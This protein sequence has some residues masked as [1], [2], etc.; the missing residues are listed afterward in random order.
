MYGYVFCGSVSFIV[1]L[2]EERANVHARV[3]LFVCSLSLCVC[4]LTRMHIHTFTHIHIHSHTCTYIHIHP[5]T[6]QC[7][8]VYDYGDFLWTPSQEKKCSPSPATLFFVH[9]TFLWEPSVYIYT[10]TS[11]ANSRGLGR[12][13]QALIQKKT[14]DAEASWKPP[15]LLL[16]K[17][18]STQ[19]LP[20]ITHVILGVPGSLVVPHV[21][22]QEFY[23]AIA[24]DYREDNHAA[25]LA[26]LCSPHRCY[27]FYVEGSMPACVADLPFRCADVICDVV[28][29]FVRE[30]FPNH[31]MLPQDEAK[32]CKKIVL[33]SEFAWRCIF[34]NFLVSPHQGAWLRVACNAQLECQ[35]LPPLFP[36]NEAE[37]PKQREDLIALLFTAKVMKQRPSQTPESLAAA[38]LLGAPCY[39]LCELCAGKD[40]RFCGQCGGSGRI[41]KPGHRLYP[42]PAS[43]L[44]SRSFEDQLLRCSIFGDEPNAS[45]TIPETQWRVPGWAPCP[46]PP[47]ATAPQRH[48]KAPVLCEALLAELE[49]TV[50]NVNDKYHQYVYIVAVEF[51]KPTGRGERSGCLDTNTGRRQPIN[52]EGPSRPEI[53]VHPQ[54]GYILRLGGLES[55]YCP[56][57]DGYHSHAACYYKLTPQGLQLRCANVDDQSR[58]PLR[59]LCVEWQGEI[60][61]VQDSVI[62]KL[63]P[64]YGYTRAP[65]LKPDQI[66][67]ISMH[68]LLP[69]TSLL[70]SVKKPRFVSPKD[71][72]ELAA[73]DALYTL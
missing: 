25:P 6:C 13:V 52:A 22:M 9:I 38:R 2:G 11:M 70:E 63:W 32:L 30:A 40:S 58:A 29:R 15:I 51:A 33:T 46:R 3:V 65:S 66:S 17:Q 21:R 34:P 20:T 14:T 5:H 31:A 37:D 59:L 16:D 56:N 43:N 47:T 68:T 42:S 4:A 10:Q 54:S 69:S 62:R 44:A 1:S 35:H 18:F 23:K 57:I 48:L 60:I 45:P 50:R 26:E 71:L 12:H 41:Q 36:R 24:D 7:F 61:R 49:E 67:S 19:L 39:I 73:F 53:V 55:R 28:Q 8:L 64:T 27:R 72:E